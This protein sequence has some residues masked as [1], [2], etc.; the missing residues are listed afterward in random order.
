MNPSILGAFGALLVI[1]AVAGL[2]AQVAG[3]VV[4]VLVAVLLVGLLLV[5]I[6]RVLHL[7]Q[8]APSPEGGQS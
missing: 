2:V 8:P 4:A 1:A 7:N 6:A 5:W 3:A